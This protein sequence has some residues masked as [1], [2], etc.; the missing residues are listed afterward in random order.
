MDIKSVVPPDTTGWL[1]PTGVGTNTYFLGSANYII[2]GNL[3]M[4]T[5]DTL[6]V[7]GFATLYVS[8]NVSM[9]GQSQ[10]VI[11]PGA[12]LK[13]YVA[14]ASAGFTTVNAPSL[15]S[16][17][18]FAFQYYGLDSHTSLS[19]SG[20]ADYVGLVYAPQAS[21]TCGGGGNNTYDY[22]GS[23][24]VNNVTMNGHFNFHYDE[25]LKRNGPPSGFTI[26]SW[27]EL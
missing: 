24:V 7:A 15:A 18:A 10:I 3:S 12:Q 22:Q 14:G 16:G 9:S 4:K 8:G 23:C 6:Y 17:N 2:N 25:N 11:A 13:I 21:F 26:T 1:T 27:Q 5:G 20:N 19:W